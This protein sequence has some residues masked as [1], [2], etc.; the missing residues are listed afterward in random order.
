MIKSQL[1]KNR[2]YP[3][4]YQANGRSIPMKWCK[5]EEPDSNAYHVAKKHEACRRLIR[6]KTQ[7]CN[8]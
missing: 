8:A 7:Q 6:L 1:G 4:L 3:L 2:G 5:A